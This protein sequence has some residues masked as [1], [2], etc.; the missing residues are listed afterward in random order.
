MVL[1][2]VLISKEN[3]PALNMLPRHIVRHGYEL[4]G[5]YS[6]EERFLAA[7]KLVKPKLKLIS[8]LE[9]FKICI[10]LLWLE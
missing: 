5:S 10:G 1:I 3:K 9:C 4:A 7:R 8:K 2:S 6:L